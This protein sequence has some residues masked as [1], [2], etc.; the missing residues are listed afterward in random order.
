MAVQE[1]QRHDDKTLNASGPSV[2]NSTGNNATGTPGT[3]IATGAGGNRTPPE[4]STSPGPGGGVDRAAAERERLRLREQ[5][6]RRR[7]AVSFFLD[8]FFYKCKA[9]GIFC[10]RQINI[11]INI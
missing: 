9:K 3:V 8:F 4:D 7:E 2:V 11:H 10:L 6:R 5:E 1:Q